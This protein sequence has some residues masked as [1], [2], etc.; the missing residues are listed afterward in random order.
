MEEVNTTL[1]LQAKPTA[2]TDIKESPAPATYKVFGVKA[3]KPYLIIFPISD[4][5]YE[6]KPSAPNFIINPLIF[7]CL[8]SLLLILSIPE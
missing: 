8:I 5:S 2:I 4:F 7:N 3:G 1:C 6:I